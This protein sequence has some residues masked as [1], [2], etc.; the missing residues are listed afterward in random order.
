MLSPRLFNVFTDRIM[1]VVKDIGY[2]SSP[3]CTVQILLLADDIVVCIQRRR[4]I[5][6]DL[7][8]MKE[9]ME[10]CMGNENVK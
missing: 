9:V 8:E 10:K 1:R 4:K 3:P 7:A 5:W 2:S 6:K